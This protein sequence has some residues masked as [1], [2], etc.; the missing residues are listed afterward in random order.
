M[1]TDPLP[2]GQFQ[3]L[4]ADPPWATTLWSGDERTPTQKRG[5]DHYAVLT[6]DQ[7]KAIPVAAAAAKNALLALWT[8]G[9]HLDQAL[10]LGRAWGFSY[11]TDLFYW[12]KQ[13][14]LRPNQLDMFTGDVHP[15]KL[16]MGKHSRKQVEP[17]LLFSRGKGLKV[18]DHAVRQLIV[19]PAREHSRKPEEARDGLERLYGDVTRLELFSRTPRAGW[20][21][22]GN[23]VD[24]FSD[25]PERLSKGEE[26]A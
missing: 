7:L 15:A 13:R 26:L 2:P 9:S 10:D 19:A 12:A 6:L 25:Y 23:E 20:I 5:E 1:T 16:G 18:H 17:C 4:Y 11:A 8:I 21:H 14:H 3:L 24:K 22:W